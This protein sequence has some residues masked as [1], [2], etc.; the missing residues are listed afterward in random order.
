MPRAG[1]S[2]QKR[3]GGIVID[4]VVEHSRNDKDFFGTR[5][6]VVFANP[7]G[8]RLDGHEG[9]LCAIAAGPQHLDADS[10]EQLAWL[11]IAGQDPL[12]AVSMRP[13]IVDV[14][15]CLAHKAV[16]DRASRHLPASYVSNAIGRLVG[17]LNPTS[18]FQGAGPVRWGLGSRRVTAFSASAISTRAR[19]APRQ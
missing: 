13:E 17:P 7:D 14:S 1:R 9:C 19:F 4:P 18:G 16:N 10:R 3:S 2:V 11:D 12:V 6:V 15:L 5:R 8:T